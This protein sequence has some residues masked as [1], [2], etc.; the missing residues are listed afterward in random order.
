M[1]TVL[2]ALLAICSSQFSLTLVSKNIVIIL[3]GLILAGAS[4]LFIDQPIALWFSLPETESYRKFAFAI[5]DIGL[6]E[7]WFILA[8]LVFFGS[9]MLL[10]IKTNLRSDL[11]LRVL[12]LKNWGAHQFFALCTS[13]LLLQISKHL[14][15]RQRPHISPERYPFVF[16]PL[17]NHWDWHSF[18]SGHTQTLFCVATV[19]GCLLPKQRLLFWIIAGLLAFTRVMSVQHFCSDVIG[20]ALL[21][22]FGS[23]LSLYYF[24]RWVPAPNK[25]Q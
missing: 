8:I 4:A 7:H 18:P 13:G 6:S 25:F 10:K 9:W 22:I 12:N 20:G 16:R 5:T 21:G 2:R 17:T 15:G 3:F 23:Q 1:D 24:S 19:V 14:V 11:N